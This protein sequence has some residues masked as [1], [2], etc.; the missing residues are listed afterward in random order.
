MTNEQLEF[1]VG[2]LLRAQGLTLSVAE[3]CTGGLVGHRLT[4][5]PG[6]STYFLGGIISYDYGI[7]ERVLGVSHDTLA[8]HGAVSPQ[9]AQEMAQQARALFRS[10][11]ALSI[12]GIAGPG[13]DIPGKPVGLTYIHLSAE[14][15][16]WCE[17]HVWQGDRQE[18]KDASAEAALDLLR[19]YLEGVP[20]G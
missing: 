10:D 14:G 4:N 15:T 8:Q 13:G 5:V 19:R 17:Q 6:S 9:V 2:R 20:L 12:T 16:E 11:V 1:T 18:N 7:K 3:S